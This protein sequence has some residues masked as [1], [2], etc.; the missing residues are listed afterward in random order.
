MASNAA[1]RALILQELVPDEPRSFA[2]LTTL[3]ASAPAAA[4]GHGVAG[5]RMKASAQAVVGAVEPGGAAALEVRVGDLLVA[6]DGVATRTSGVL[7]RLQA[8]SARNA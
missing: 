8:C 7:A 2:L 5:A 1:L 6:V 3:L 4:G